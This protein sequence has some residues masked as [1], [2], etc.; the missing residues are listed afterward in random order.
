[1]T[2]ASSIYDIEILNKLNLHKLNPKE[3]LVNCVNEVEQKRVDLLIFEHPVINLMTSSEANDKN[4]FQSLKLINNEKNN[5]QKDFHYPLGIFINKKNTKLYQE[6][7][8]QIDE[9]KKSNPNIMDNL[10]EK[11]IKTYINDNHQK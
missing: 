7:T 9:I 5:Q 2:T 10:R 11:A 1:T 6:L 8:K 3:D 4:K